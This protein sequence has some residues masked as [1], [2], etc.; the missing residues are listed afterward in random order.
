MVNK[1]ITLILL[2]FLLLIIAYNEIQRIN[3]NLYTEDAIT[4]Y[5]EDGA[6]QEFIDKIV[7]EFFYKDHFSLESV[8]FQSLVFLINVIVLFLFVKFNRL[9]SNFGLVLLISVVV[10]IM[11][12]FIA[13][14]GYFNVWQNVLKFILSFTFLDL[15]IYWFV[16]RKNNM[17]LATVSFLSI[18]IIQTVDLL[19]KS[20]NN[21]NIYIITESLILLLAVIFAIIV[22]LNSSK[23]VTVSGDPTSAR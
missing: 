1:P 8:F 10:A 4:E 15:T 5:K 17:F 21:M 19:V 22:Y 23:N 12:D 7:S 2:S 16:K 14:Q 13:S 20:Y 6:S 18:F 9:I 11:T 3:W